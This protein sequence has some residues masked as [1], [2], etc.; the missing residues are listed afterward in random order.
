MDQARTRVSSTRE[1]LEQMF[2]PTGPSA[3]VRADASD[4]K[5]ERIVDLHFEPY[6]RLAQSEGQGSPPAIT[7]TTGLINELYTYLTAADAALRSASPAPGSDVVTKLRAE[8]GRSEE[9]TSELQSLMRISYAV[10]F[11]NKKN[12]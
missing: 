12:K 1:A 11:L 9:H 8:A 5:L 6:R 2:G 3:A 10:F 4:D 7:A